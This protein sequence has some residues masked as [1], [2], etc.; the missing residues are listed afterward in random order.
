VPD[1]LKFSWRYWEG[2]PRGVVKTPLPSAARF[3]HTEQVTVAVVWS[4]SPR[5]QGES[6]AHIATGVEAYPWSCL[7]TR[8][9]S[10]GPQ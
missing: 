8:L 4:P 5:R 6:S 3:S 1:S 7:L 9:F 2:G 10:G